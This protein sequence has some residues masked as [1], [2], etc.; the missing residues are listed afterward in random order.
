[1][2]IIPATLEVKDRRIK[3][4][5]PAQAKLVKTLSEKQK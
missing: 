2:P 3:V 5:K 4:A 1:M